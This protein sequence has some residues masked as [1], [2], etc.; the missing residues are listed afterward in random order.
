[1]AL[2]DCLECRKK[3]SDLAAACPHCGAPSGKAPTGAN[4]PVC[5]IPLIGVTQKAKVSLGGI[6]GAFVVLIGLGAVLFNWIVG[7]LLILIGVIVSLA[8]GSK[9]VMKCPQC[10]YYGATL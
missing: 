8:R 10:G 9:T 5:R 6:V 2:V 3:I 7:L 4:C 1:M